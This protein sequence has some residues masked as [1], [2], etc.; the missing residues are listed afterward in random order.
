[1]GVIKLNVDKVEAPL[2]PS[3]TQST[4]D[5]LR[6]GSVRCL[7][8]SF[9]LSEENAVSILEFAARV[10]YKSDV[11]KR[12]ALN[13]LHFL[14]QREHLSVFEHVN[15]SFFLS[16]AFVSD[17]KNL[18]ASI[19]RSDFFSIEDLH[20]KEKVLVICNLRSLIELYRYSLEC[21]DK[22]RDLI[23][24]II[25]TMKQIW[26]NIYSM[27]TTNHINKE[28]KKNV[29]FSV[30]KEIIIP[31]MIV[32][33]NTRYV[34]HILCTRAIGNQ[35]VRHRTL[36]YSQE[37]SRFIMYNKYDN[38]DLSV[39]ISDTNKQNSI[40]TDR[41]ENIAS[42]SMEIYCQGIADGL[43]PEDARD[44]LPLGTKTEIVVSGT[45]DVSMP[46][47]L[48]TGFARFIDLRNDNHAQSSIR[49]IAK[50]IISYIHKSQKRES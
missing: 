10:C 19:K 44:F 43:K 5:T 18:I 3:I 31:S 7:N 41:M 35:F 40:Y 23:I 17:F 14:Y 39:Y 11:K 46:N 45:Y 6:A 26:P 50:K 8:N 16:Q 9:L 25:H 15:Y 12:D 38:S 47:F 27:I 1:M 21:S 28:P 29:A 30:E 37:S 48:Y 34:F 36:S 42:L 13:L 4:I 49:E 20:S 33:R 24:P 22:S 2:L 32:D